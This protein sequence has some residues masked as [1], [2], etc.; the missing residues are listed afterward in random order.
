MLAGHYS[1]WAQILL[2]GSLAVYHLCIFP[3]LCIILLAIF[4]LIAIAI[5]F[6]REYKESLLWASTELARFLFRKEIIFSS[7]L[8]QYE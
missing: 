1:L 5:G 7:F 8:I 4:A 2:A 3:T 6:P